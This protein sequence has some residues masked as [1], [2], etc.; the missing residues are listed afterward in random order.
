MNFKELCEANK[1]IKTTDIK[2]KEYAEVN[3]RIKA[4]RSVFP[5]GSIESEIVSYEN[6]TVVM[7]AIAK[8]EEG[9]IL[10]VGHAYEH[11]NSSFINKTSAI[12][13]CETSAVGRALGMVGFGIDVSIASYEEV[14]NAIENQNTM[15]AKK[16][17]ETTP[18]TEDE[19]KKKCTE[20]QVSFLEKLVA[21]KHYNIEELLTKM[22]VKS[23]NE[24]TSAQAS[25]WINKLKG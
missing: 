9:K 16:A 2:G 1:L 8:D 6:G 24:L 4:F 15:K 19:A 20:A 18:K 17:M 11:E 5:N 3:Q 13:N 21:D 14:A 10:G 12:E 22:N 7:K 23:L 25:V